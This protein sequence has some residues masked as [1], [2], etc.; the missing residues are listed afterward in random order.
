MITKNDLDNYRDALTLKDTIVQINKRDAQTPM[1]EDPHAP[2]AKMANIP[3]SDFFTQATIRLPIYTQS[4]SIFAL[5]PR[6]KKSSFLT[7]SGDAK[8]GQIIRYED[9]KENYK[10][11]LIIRPPENNKKQ[12]VFVK[13]LSESEYQKIRK[14]DIFLKTIKL[15]SVA[16][17]KFRPTTTDKIMQ[18]LNDFLEDMSIWLLLIFLTLALLFTLYLV[19]FHEFK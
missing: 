13:T 6:Q 1:K 9:A 3:A 8:L 19:F 14:N 10:Y 18:T 4:N 11:G 5:T 12:A 2:V 7:V 15:E 17:H 16:I